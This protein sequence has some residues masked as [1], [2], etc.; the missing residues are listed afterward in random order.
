MFGIDTVPVAD[1]FFWGYAALGA[2][3]I[4]AHLSAPVRNWVMLFC[5]W[6]MGAGFGYAWHYA[7]AGR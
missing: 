7:A 3:L 4:F 5:S 6:A 1:L 2:V